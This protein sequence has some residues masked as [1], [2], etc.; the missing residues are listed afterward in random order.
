[1]KA[2]GRGHRTTVECLVRA[3]ADI[4]NINKVYAV[5]AMLREL[6]FINVL[7]VSCYIVLC[8]K[9]ENF[10]MLCMFFI[11]CCISSVM[12]YY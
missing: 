4:E 3:G 6:I 1:M 2:A 9:T 5:D 7:F 12:L 10:D 8:N 11:L